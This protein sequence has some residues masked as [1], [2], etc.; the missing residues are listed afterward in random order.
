[1]EGVSLVG[2]RG[3][4]QSLFATKEAVVGSLVVGLWGIVPRTLGR[5][6]FE[7]MSPPSLSRLFKTQVSN[8]D[9][10]GSGIVTNDEFKRF[11]T[12]TLGLT[13]QNADDVLA[14]LCQARVFAVGLQ[15]P[16]D[17]QQRI[18]AARG[19][20]GECSGPQLVAIDR[21]AAGCHKL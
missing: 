15:G 3:F 17:G 19:M 16:G 7:C 5:L 12:R 21:P 14:S 20:F 10:D 13:S 9:S 4:L 8:M 6:A 2:F 1:M 18:C 11:V